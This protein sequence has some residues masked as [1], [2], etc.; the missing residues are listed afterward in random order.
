I[1]IGT[2]LWAV[3]FTSI[4]TRPVTRV[5]AS[6]WIFQNIPKGATL[7]YELWD[8]ALPLNVDGRLADAS[9]RQIRMDLYWEDVPE[10]REQLY[11]WLQDTEYIILSSNRLYGSIPR[12]PLRYP[13]TRRYYQALFSGELGYDLIATFTSYPRIFG[14]EIVDDAADESFTVYDHPKVLIFKKRPDF[15]LENV[16]AIL[17]G[18]P[19]DRVVRMLP[20]QV[21]AAP[22]GLMLY[23]S[24]WAAQQAGGTWAEIFDPNSLMNQLPLLWWLLI[25]EGLG[26]LAFPLAFAA[27]GAL[28]DRGFALAK[29][30]GLLLWGYITW[31]L[32]SLKWLP[33]TR[34][35]IAGA[36][37][38]LAVLSLGVGLW[39]RAAIGAFLKARWRLIIAYEVAF[40]AA[41]GAFLWVRCN[42]PDLWHPVTG[43]ENRWIWPTLRPS[44]KASPSRRMTLGSPAGR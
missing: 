20:K 11:Q 33:Y 43:G 26:W 9:Y 42:N 1:V 29:V 24:E 40:L 15:S 19:L 16:K 36:L 21:S 34:Q 31:L 38:G 12:L 13:V 22:N 28:R 6:R 32:P 7:S 4:Y 8:D 23:R 2:G 18:Y 41:F 25:L 5:A 27:L 30:V 39:R 3:A 44:S 17:G 14:F 10:K 37:V 35:L